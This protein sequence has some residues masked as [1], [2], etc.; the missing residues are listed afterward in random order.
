MLEEENRK[1]PLD[2]RG[3]FKMI[4]KNSAKYQTKSIINVFKNK[5][6]HNSQPIP[7]NFSRES[8]LIYKIRF[9]VSLLKRLVSR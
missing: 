5:I 4:P 3:V 1:F 8:D 9:A 2:K 7:A 6:I